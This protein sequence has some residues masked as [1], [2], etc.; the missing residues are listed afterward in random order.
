MP[1]RRLVS[2]KAADLRTTRSGEADPGHQHNRQRV[3]DFGKTTARKGRPE[4]LSQRVSDV[5]DPSHH[6]KFGVYPPVP[7]SS[8]VRHSNRR[9]TPSHFPKVMNMIGPRWPWRLLIDGIAMQEPSQ[10]TVGVDRRLPAVPFIERRFLLLGSLYAGRVDSFSI[11]SRS[12]SALLA[13]DLQPD[14]GRLHR[15]QPAA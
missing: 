1:V 15:H 4:R 3:A 6:K 2:A 7:S 5:T 12:R 14:S 9:R 8:V 11:C 13:C 10:S